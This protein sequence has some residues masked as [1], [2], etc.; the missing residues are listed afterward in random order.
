MQG[1]HDDY[2]KPLDVEWLCR[3][4]HV[5]E[6][7]DERAEQLPMCP[8]CGKRVA[9]YGLKTCGAV[10]CVETAIKLGGAMSAK[11]NAG[12][13]KETAA[14]MR[15]LMAENGWSQAELA[16]QMNVS[17]AYVSVTLKESRE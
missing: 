9:G 2:D 5:Q 8:H 11:P 6:H 1:H 17:R 7:V 13:A 16:R 15:A 12:K 3:G 4:C 14:K 10:T